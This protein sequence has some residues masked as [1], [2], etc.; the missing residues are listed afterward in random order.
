MFTIWFCG[1]PLFPERGW[2]VVWKMLICSQFQTFLQLLDTF[3]QVL[4][5]TASGCDDLTPDTARELLAFLVKHCD[6]IF[7]PP[8]ELHLEVE[9]R[10]AIL[11]RGRVSRWPCKVHVTVTMTGLRPSFGRFCDCV[12]GKFFF[13]ADVG[14]V[15]MLEVFLFHCAI[16]PLHLCYIT[17]LDML[18]CVQFFILIFPWSCKDLTRQVVVYLLS[19]PCK[20]MLNSFLFWNRH[21]AKFTSNNTTCNGLLNITVKNPVMFPF[22][23]V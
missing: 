20:C 9:A 12:I 6:R 19:N 18:L 21:R 2:L 11:R 17:V 4:L 23:A 16:A 22:S 14:V 5:N 8:R 3:S 7:A 13:P 10:L 1:M 15:F